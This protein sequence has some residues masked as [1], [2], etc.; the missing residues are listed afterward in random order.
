M[1][2]AVHLTRFGA[3]EEVIQIMDQIP[4]TPGLGQVVIDLEIANINP[5]DC[6]TVRGLY[7]I[8]PKAFPAPLGNEGIGRISAV[9]EGVTE[10]WIGQRV[11]LPL[12]GGIWASQVMGRADKLMPL[13]EGLPAEQ[14]AMALVNPPT[15]YLLLTAVMPQQEGAW[16]IQN[17]ANSSVGQAVNAFAPDLGLNIINLVR[18]DTAA[19]TLKRASHV[20]RT[21]DPD[22]KKQIKAL[23]EDDRPLLA[24]DAIGGEA[25]MQLADLLGPGGSVVSYGALSGHACKLAPQ[26]TIFKGISL[27]GFWLVNW[28]NN[29]S[30]QDQMSMVARVGEKII[31][32]TLQIPV[33]ATYDLADAAKALQHSEQPGRS[34]KILFKGPAAN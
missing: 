24:F 25:T 26:H 9:G 10:T 8:L 1:G 20:F 2:I 13:P 29:A 16:V 17:A 27:R 12:G 5:S 23:V 15:A 19:K 28:F 6:L 7:G 33:E 18:S 32:G 4:L 31:D 34:G 11:A 14:L 3:P 30:A 21:D 22:L